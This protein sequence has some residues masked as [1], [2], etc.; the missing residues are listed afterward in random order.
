MAG[1]WW[2]RRGGSGSFDRAS[3]ITILSSPGT[4]AAM[5]HPTTYVPV[6]VLRQ[7]ARD[8]VGGA[9]APIAR[10]AVRGRNRSGPGKHVAPAYCRV[11]KQY[12]SGVTSALPRLRNALSMKR[13]GA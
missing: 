10:C 8:P 1:R 3:R 11:Q 12:A 2:W 9:P 6:R 4:E 7:V 5:R 13:N